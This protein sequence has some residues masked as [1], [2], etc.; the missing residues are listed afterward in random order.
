MRSLHE[1]ERA[2]DGWVWLDRRK[3]TR[4]K[5]NGQGEVEAAHCNGNKADWV[6]CSEVERPVPEGSTPVYWA[7]PGTTLKTVIFAMHKSGTAPVALFDD[8]D[9]FVGSIGVRNVLQAILRRGG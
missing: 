5:L 4:F 3:T 7:R 8:N 1:L 2:E 6:C 9:C